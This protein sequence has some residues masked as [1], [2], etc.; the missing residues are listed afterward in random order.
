MH[1]YLAILVAVV[2]A[3]CTSTSQHRYWSTYQVEGHDG[4]L[5]GKSAEQVQILVANSVLGKLPA[6]RYDKPVRLVRAPQP[7]MSPAD[8]DS[9]IVGRVVADLLFSESGDVE[10]VSIVESSKDSLA[11]SVTAAVQQWRITPA[12]KDGK[13]VKVRARQVF[14]F[15]TDW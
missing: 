14:D 3:G 1:Q 13:P 10:S 6:Q 5:D 15:K 7:V 12:T 9:R 8:T 4:E 11:A 2:L